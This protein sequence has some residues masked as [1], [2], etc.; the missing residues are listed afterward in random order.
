MPFYFFA[1]DDV[2]PPS[3]ASEELPNDEAA[4]EAARRI[5]SELNRN[6]PKRTWVTVWNDR[7]QIIW[8]T[9]E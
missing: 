5:A 8:R 2:P 6:R 9:E 4:R 7:R 1:Y 3:E